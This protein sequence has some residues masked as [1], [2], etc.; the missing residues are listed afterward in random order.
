MT[1]PD[2]PERPTTGEDSTTQPN[3][4]GDA[5]E[6]HC[7]ESVVEVIEGHRPQPWELDRSKHQSGISEEYRQA[8][9]RDLVDATKPADLREICE[10]YAVSMGT[11]REIL[12]EVRQERETASQLYDMRVAEMIEERAEDLLLRGLT[13]TK[14]E[15]AGIRDNAIAFGILADKL[16]QFR[17]QQTG[18]GGTRARI[19]WKGA[20]GS[21]MAV[22]IS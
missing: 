5:T 20:D 11:V 6:A 19:A 8:I 3:T 16:A 13:K 17:G 18:D 10:R 4:P 22:E 12:L 15:K 7:G 9:A 21:A 14:M 2:T 1:T